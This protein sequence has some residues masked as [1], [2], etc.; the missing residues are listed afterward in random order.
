MANNKKL[1]RI[2]FTPVGEGP[3]PYQRLKRLLK[4]ALRG[5]GLRVVKAEEVI[6]DLP[7]PLPDV[8]WPELPF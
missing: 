6:E 4:A 3:P 7:V 2:D 1:F 5:Y 8:E